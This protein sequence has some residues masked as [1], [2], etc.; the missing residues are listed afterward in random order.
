M[1]WP[2]NA[3]MPS[4]RPRQIHLTEHVR[5]FVSVIQVGNGGSREINSSYE[6][7]HDSLAQGKRPRIT[8]RY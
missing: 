1:R 5:K 8:K 4:E 2:A 7:K 6:L 3:C